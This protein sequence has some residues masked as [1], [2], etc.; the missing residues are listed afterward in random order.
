MTTEDA[1]GRPG[2]TRG[3]ARMN[4]EERVSALEEQIA[5]LRKQDPE[6][7]TSFANAD[8]L[9]KNLDERKGKL[10]AEQSQAIQ[11]QERTL[12]SQQG[13]PTAIRWAF[14]LMGDDRVCEAQANW[15]KTLAPGDPNLGF[16][17]VVHGVETNGGET[18]IWLKAERADEIKAWI[19][20]AVA[21]LAHVQSPAPQSRPVVISRAS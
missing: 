7:V 4:T 13:R 3:E 5:A 16:L 11:S 10:V 18:L 12:Q 21:R 17:G 14:T 15:L 1:P 2:E 20:N 19:T 8:D 6:T 9:M